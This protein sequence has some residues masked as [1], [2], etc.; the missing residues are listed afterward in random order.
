VKRTEETLE[1][2]ITYLE[3]KEMTSVLAN[4]EILVRQ[5]HSSVLSLYEIPEELDD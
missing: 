2:L 4:Y 5:Q 3:F 1:N